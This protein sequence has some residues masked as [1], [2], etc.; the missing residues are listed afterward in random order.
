MPYVLSHKCTRHKRVLSAR[1]ARRAPLV[2]FHKHHPYVD[3]TYLTH[4][5]R[6]LTPTKLL[7]TPSL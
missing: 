3:I 5:A 4:R 7:S 1:G 2:Y 6:L